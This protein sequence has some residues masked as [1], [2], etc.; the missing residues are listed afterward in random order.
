MQTSGSSKCLIRSQKKGKV[1]HQV[2]ACDLSSKSSRS[3]VQCM[4]FRVFSCLVSVR[5]INPL[6][7]IVIQP[8]SQAAVAPPLFPH[9]LQK[10][11]LSILV[12][13]ALIEPHARA[14]PVPATH[15]QVSLEDLPVVDEDD[16]PR[17]SAEIAALGPDELA[18]LVGQAAVERQRAQLVLA[19]DVGAARDQVVVAVQRD[20][21]ARGREVAS[22]PVTGIARL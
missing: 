22:L 10:H 4:S 3:A 17:T 16:I 5:I 7:E 8:T 2:E 1:S 12:T 13:D 11:Q 14:I 9:L 21:V 19:V 18:V 20:R 15:A 6:K